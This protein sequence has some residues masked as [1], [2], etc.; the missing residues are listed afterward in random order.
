MPKCDFS[1]V[2]LATLQE[3]T[4][5]K[6][7]SISNFIEITLW[8]GSSPVNLLHIL[9]TSFP[10]NISGRR[11]LTDCYFQQEQ[12]FTQYNLLD[13]LKKVYNNWDFCASNHPPLNG[14]GWISKDV[15]NI[16]HFYALVTET[17]TSAPLQIGC[18]SMSI[19]S[20]TICRLIKGSIGYDQTRSLLKQS[21]NSSFWIISETF[22]PLNY[23]S[24]LARFFEA[25]CK[26]LI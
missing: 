14:I 1:K 18:L 23:Q 12:I 26:S 8:H 25:L 2:A 21:R 13:L 10:K 6:V 5:G 24:L 15:R 11:L 20:T 17:T 7:I 16:L 9:R 3:N 4:H 22:S 19:S